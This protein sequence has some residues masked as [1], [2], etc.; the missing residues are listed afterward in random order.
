LL[1]TLSATDCASISIPGNERDDR[2]FD[3]QPV[4]NLSRSI[5]AAA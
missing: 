1:S 2:D 3:P 4:E 5:P